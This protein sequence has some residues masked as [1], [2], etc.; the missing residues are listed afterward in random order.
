MNLSTEDQIFDALV[1]SNHVFKKINELIDLSPVVLEIRKLY[2][3]K[4]E[5]GFDAESGLR[6]LLIQFWE[7]YSDRQMEQAM[8]ENIAIKYFCKLGLTE[9]TP[10][11]SY[12]G[13]LR[14]R[15][16]TAR[17]HD[18]FEEINKQ[19]A[20]KGYSGS[21]FSVIDASTIITKTKL[22]EERDRAIADGEKKLNN[23]V[24][25]KYTTDKDAKWGAKGK[26]NIWF[27]YKRHVSVDCRFGLIEKVCVSP[28]NL[29]DFK[30]IRNIVPRNKGIYTDKG[31]DYKEATNE[32]K[33]V[34]STHL[35]IQK[36][37]NKDKNYDR[38]SYRTKIRMPFESTFSKVNKYARYKGIVKTSFQVFME[39]IV[40]N[41][42][43]AITYESVILHA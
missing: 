30:S 33:R 10:D 12:F 31:Y 18:L 15:I 25:N 8:R 26:N 5:I 14:T 41:V 22:W 27:G 4:G 7:D 20:L 38:D 2:S 11:H 42:K 16:G 1:P 17:I 24:V 39:S 29:P 6:A 35:N 9:K 21:V 19:L 40:F 36:N 34:G 13:R 23:K 37:S 3:N 32:I 43:K 28:T